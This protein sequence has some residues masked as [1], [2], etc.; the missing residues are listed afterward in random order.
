MFFLTLKNILTLFTSPVFISDE[1]KIF[2][3][4]EK[5][6]TLSKDHIYFFLTLKK[7]L[8]L[9]TGPLFFSEGF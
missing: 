1:F 9:P 3:S 7:I 6:R 8:T 2:L 4:L 5:S